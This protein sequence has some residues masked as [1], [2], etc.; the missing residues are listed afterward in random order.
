MKHA[1]LVA[2]G[3]VV[4]AAGCRRREPPPPPPP[5]VET[6][7]VEDFFREPRHPYTAR[8]L[9]SL[10]KPDGEIR[11]IGGEIPSLVNPPS[12][13]RF[14]PR[15]AS[16]LPVCAQERPGVEGEAPLPEED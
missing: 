9:D 10:P 4:A 1:T 15:C 14:H 3:M 16:A 2:V 12:G 7:P 13:C 11:E 8:L 5:E 6:A